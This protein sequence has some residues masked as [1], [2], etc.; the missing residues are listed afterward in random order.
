MQLCTK[1]LIVLILAPAIAFCTT[2][3]PDHPETSAPEQSHHQESHGVKQTLEHHLCDATY[4]EF[5]GMKIELPILF[6]IGDTPVPLTK[7][8]VFWA[9]AGLLLL[10]MGL[11]NARKVGGI[12][13]GFANLLEVFIIFLRDEV[14]YPAMGEKDGRKWLPFFLT[15]FFFILIANLLGMVPWGVTSTGNI[16]MTSGMA[17]VI[18]IL[19][20]AAG[21]VYNGPIGFLKSF[22]PAGVPIFVQPILFVIEIIGLFVKSFALC[23]RLFA[24]MLAGHAVIAVLMVLITSLLIAP[25]SILGAVAIS[26]LELFVAFLQAYIF[27]ILSATFMGMII[28]PSH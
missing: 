21:V 12:P 2:S 14:V 26:L 20:F 7:H 4:V 11:I 24:N 1:L 3:T 8:M 6:T 5:L 16:S 13:K 18:L 19:L 17:L 9:V 28:H 22:M 27:T 15:V 23:M 25:I 10:W